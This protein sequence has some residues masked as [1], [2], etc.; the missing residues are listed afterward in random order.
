[1]AKNLRRALMTSAFLLATLHVGQARG[2]GPAQPTWNPAAAAKYLDSRADWWL[3]WS[4]SARGQGTACISCHTTL[5]FALAR[6]AL[7]ARLGETEL[8]STE[9]KLIDVLKK[10]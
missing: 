8:G 1:M 7:A 6:P 9:K 2:G 10:R 3:H 5:P 4:S